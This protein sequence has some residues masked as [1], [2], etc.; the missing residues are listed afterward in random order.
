MES[1]LRS[2]KVNASY[3]SSSDSSSQR[4]IATLRNDLEEMQNKCMEKDEQISTLTQEIQSLQNKLS[5]AETGIS[6]VNSQLTEASAALKSMSERSGSMSSISSALESNVQALKKE[7]GALKLSL[8]AAENEAKLLKLKLDNVPATTV[9]VKSDDGERYEEEIK[10]L[11]Q[12]IEELNRE[13]S[14]TTDHLDNLRAEVTLTKQVLVTVSFSHIIKFDSCLFS[15][16]TI[17]SK[18]R[19]HRSISQSTESSTTL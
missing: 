7:N 11:Q 8:Q 1:E 14:V 16:N 10:R 19:Q 17:D 6:C 12:T 15:R 18:A 3:S 9:V 2:L 5:D 4:E 13:K